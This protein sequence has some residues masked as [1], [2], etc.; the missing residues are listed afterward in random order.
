MTE[1]G[2]GFKGEGSKKEFR[3]IK[4]KKKTTCVAP[5]SVAAAAAAAAATSTVLK[6]LKKRM[7][8]ARRGDCRLG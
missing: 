1:S 3:K 2:E 6:T 8:P 7:V 5:L 4:G